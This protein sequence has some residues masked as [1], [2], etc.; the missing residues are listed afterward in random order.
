M[1]INQ[2]TLIQQACNLKLASVCIFAGKPAK[3]TVSF[4]R[5][6]GLLC[7]VDMLNAWNKSTVTGAKYF[8]QFRKNVA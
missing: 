7:P 6:G 5:I 3:N 2:E 8:T 1:I 4:S